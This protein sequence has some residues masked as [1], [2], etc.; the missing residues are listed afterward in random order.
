MIIKQLH[1][2][3]LHVRSQK[4]GII[5]VILSVNQYNIIVEIKDTY[6]TLVWALSVKDVF[7]MVE[8]N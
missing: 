6:I 3:L 8:L 4:M 2:I 5:K 1:F 7:D